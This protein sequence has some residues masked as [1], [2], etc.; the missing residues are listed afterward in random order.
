MHFDGTVSLGSLLNCA[1]IMGA[2]FMLYGRFA[3]ME[4]KVNAIWEWF[5]EELA[6]RRRAERRG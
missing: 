1:A 2:A 4:T 6:D 5:T 3:S